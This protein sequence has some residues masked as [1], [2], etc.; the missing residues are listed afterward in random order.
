MKIVK[1]SKNPG[2]AIHIYSGN[3]IF[4]M[5]LLGLLLALAGWLMAFVGSCLFKELL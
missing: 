1:P 5:T 3:K 4:F 2:D